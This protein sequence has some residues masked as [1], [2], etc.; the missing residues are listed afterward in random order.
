MVENG[1]WYTWHKILFKLF[2]CQDPETDPRW[3]QKREAF[4]NRHPERRCVVPPIPSAGISMVNDYEK[5]G[6]KSGKNSKLSCLMR[7]RLNKSRIFPENRLS[8]SLCRFIMPRSS[9]LSWR[10]NPS[11]IRATQTGNFVWW[12]MDQRICGVSILHLKRKKRICGSDFIDVKKMG[13]L[14]LLQM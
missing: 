4:L 8:L 9:G 14:R 2:G 3:P 10:L 6:K 7:N 13:G 1:W 11:R 12:M 5:K